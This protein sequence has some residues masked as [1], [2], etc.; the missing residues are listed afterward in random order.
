VA[1]NNTTFQPQEIFVMGHSLGG[2]GARHYFDGF[3]SIDQKSPFLGLALFGTQFNGDH[4]DFK[5][6]L[7]YPSNLAAF[8]APLLALTGELDFGPM[9]HVALLSAQYSQ[10]S[11]A[12]QSLKPVVIVPGMDHSQ[13]C[14]PYNVSGDIAPEISNQ[15]ALNTTSHVV[16]AWINTVLAVSTHQPA[17][18]FRAGVSILRD[19]SAVTAKICGAWLAASALEASEWC[20]TSQMALLGTLPAAVRSRVRVENVITVNS[21]ANFEHAHTKYSVDPAT[22][23][24]S[25]TTIAYPYYASVASWNPVHRLTPTYMGA[26]NVGCKALSADRV[27]QV[28]NATSHFPQPTPPV[29]CDV[30]NHLAVQKALALLEAYWPAGVHRFQA[31]GRN[32]T[33]ESDSIAHTGPTWVFF[34]SLGFKPGADTTPV[35]VQSP[36]LYSSISSSIFPGNMYCKLLSPAKALEWIQTTG[37]TGRYI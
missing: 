14:S 8:P 11:P 27:A 20:Q 10:L 5:G 28:L 19:A 16:S 6:T 36:R 13:F 17:D 15:H 23:L 7:G 4:E 29:G 34:S 32:F 12:E 3:T 37:L 9:S 25:I 31:R 21:S 2:V 24:L 35:A 30:V 22:K 33:M 26:D 18:G 1:N